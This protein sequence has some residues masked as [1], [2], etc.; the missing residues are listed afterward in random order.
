MIFASLENLSKMTIFV[1]I[2]FPFL[3]DNLFRLI[4]SIFMSHLEIASWVGYYRESRD[5][6]AFYSRDTMTISLALAN[7]RS[8]FSVSAYTLD[9]FSLTVNQH[10]IFIFKIIIF[11]RDFKLN[12]ENKR[13]KERTEKDYSSLFN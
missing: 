8:D 10:F 9:P 11:I 5:L 3:Y 13:E 4:G 1:F 2:C 12:S 6:I 7:E